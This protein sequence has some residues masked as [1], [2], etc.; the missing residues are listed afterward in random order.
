MRWYDEG[1]KKVPQAERLRPALTA[2][3][4]ALGK[5]LKKVQIVVWGDGEV[6]VGEN[7]LKPPKKPGR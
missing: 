3:R 6:I 5:P 7:V 4:A 1:L 2:L